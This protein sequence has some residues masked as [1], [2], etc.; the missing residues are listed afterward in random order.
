MAK[1]RST[2]RTRKMLPMFT[3][4]S[5]ILTAAFASFAS[6]STS[7]DEKEAHEERIAAL[8]TRVAVLEEEV[9]IETSGATHSSQTSQ[10]S[11]D[12]S[13]SSQSVSISS[14]SSSSGSY[15]VSFSSSR[16][17]EFELEIDDQD[18]YTMTIAGTSG[19]VAHL[20]D[21]NGEPMEVFSLESSDADT[22]SATGD[23]SAGHYTLRVET[24]TVW[25]ASIKSTGP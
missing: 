23:L 4:I 7:G 22:L 1:G 13:S 17:N 12:S 11:S 5:V 14:S 2:M 6:L 15:T 20:M 21:S 24:E 16:T 10:Q 25:N 3:V 8:E 9:G 19:F 18:T